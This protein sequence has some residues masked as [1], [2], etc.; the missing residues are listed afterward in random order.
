MTP[1]Q[2][3]KIVGLKRVITLVFMAFMLSLWVAAFF[4]IVKPM[5]DNS[6]NELASAKRQVSALRGK[7]NNVNND[8]EFMK[9]KIPDYE[10]ILKQGLFDDQDR[11]RVVDVVE[12]LKKDAGVYRF[13]YSIG[14]REII[15]SPAADAMGYS[16]IKRT[17]KLTGVSA[18]LDIDIFSFFQRIPKI[19]P[20]YVHIKNFKMIRK[21]EVDMNTLQ[22]IAYNEEN[23]LVSA[24]IEFDWVTLSKKDV[25]ENNT[26]EDNRRRR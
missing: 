24:D 16:L 19:L 21:K 4:F 22:K 18:L 6:D 3:V 15:P 26:K 20:L 5:K 23:E 1:Q 10:S 11:F 2:L 8:I 7:I 9:E 14:N 17:I 12:K 25:A 13:S